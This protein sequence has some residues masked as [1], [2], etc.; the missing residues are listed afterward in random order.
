MRKEPRTAGILSASHQTL[1]FTVDSNV[2]VLVE[3]EESCELSFQLVL[4]GT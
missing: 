2:S 1:L 3:A 4:T